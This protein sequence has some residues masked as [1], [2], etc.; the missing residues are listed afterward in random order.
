MR[1]NLLRQQNHQHP[2]G[3]MVN[4]TC[5]SQIWSN[6]TALPLPLPLPLPWVEGGEEED[7]VVER[8]EE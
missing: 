6:E 5:K 1:H 7:Y 2:I 4:D 8:W 3:T